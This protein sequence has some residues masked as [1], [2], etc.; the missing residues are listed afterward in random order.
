MHRNYSSRVGGRQGEFITIGR[1]SG[2]WYVAFDKL[3]ARKLT[4]QLLQGILF[5]SQSLYR[6]TNSLPN[7]FKIRNDLL[8]D[9]ARGKMDLDKSLGEQ[10][11]RL[12]F[13]CD[14]FF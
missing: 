12:L 9:R 10:G 6:L 3:M 13:I 2:G 7:L 5:L 14:G 11:D 8:W 4:H 1:A